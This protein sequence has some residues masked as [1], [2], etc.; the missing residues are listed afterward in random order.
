MWTHSLVPFAWTWRPACHLFILALL[1][2]SP[3]GHDPPISSGRVILDMSHFH[4]ESLLQVCCT[5]LSCA[6]EELSC[7]L[8]LWIPY[9]LFYFW[10]QSQFML[11]QVRGQHQ[12]SFEMV[13]ISV[14][15]KLCPIFS[16]ISNYIF[17]IFQHHK[18][19]WNILIQ[20]LL[21]AFF[22][23][24]I[25]TKEPHVR[26]DFLSSYLVSLRT[27]SQSQPTCWHVPNAWSPQVT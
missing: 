13:T 18:R 8:W 5:T 3:L 27:I 24:I 10:Q 20:A 11:Y 6:G 23:F 16:D 19:C 4:I 22:E 14:F 17:V 9:F 7:L 12:A 1:R 25:I 26:A 2:D 15:P 21:Q